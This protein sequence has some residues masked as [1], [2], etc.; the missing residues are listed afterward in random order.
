MTGN[1]PSEHLASRSPSQPLA[2]I[3]AHH[4]SGPLPHPETLAHYERVS[5][6][7]AERLLV[8][9]ESEAKHR[10]DMDRLE[11]ERARVEQDANYTSIKA[12]Q[13]IYH[14]GQI[15]AGIIVLAAMGCA[16]ALAFNGS[17]L[18]GFIG[19]ISA[20]GVLVGGF[21]WNRRAERRSSRDDDA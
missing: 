3:V 8:M 7:I 4:W 17:P 14:S 18:G 9:V 16:L 6:G 21:I 20:L 12:A 10:Q 11:A 2:E 1:E 5:P 19:L 13:R 15:I